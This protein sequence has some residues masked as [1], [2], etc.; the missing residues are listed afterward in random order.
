MGC[1]CVSSKRP[2]N[3]E[4]AHVH[5]PKMSNIKH[6]THSNTNV[7]TNFPLEEVKKDKFIPLSEKT[8]LEGY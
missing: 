6:I 8:I 7:E 4:L 2:S 1:Y 5:H 3:K